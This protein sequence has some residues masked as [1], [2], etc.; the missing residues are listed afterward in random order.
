MRAL[1]R[2]TLISSLLVWCAAAQRGGGGGHGGG[3]GGGG[4]HGGGGMGGGFHGGGSMGGGGGFRGGGGFGGG[5]NRGGFGGG[6][7]R[8]G[9]GYGYGFNRGGY[10]YGRYGYGY[11]GYY[12]GWPYWGYGWGYPGYGWGL[13]VGYWPG[14]FGYYGS[15]DYPYDYGYD[16]G[17]G[18]DPGGYA[19]SPSPNVAV[20][21]QGYPQQGYY[22]QQVVS[23]PAPAYSDTAHPVI[24]SY[25]QYGQEVG[26]SGGGTNGSPIYLIA[27]KDGVIHA[28]ASYWVQQGM[29]HYVTL[30]HEE[31]TVPVANIDHTLTNQLNRERHVNL[32]LVQ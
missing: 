11:R 2:V 26:P 16:S 8:G 29:V 6:F 15:Y 28:A 12:G 7:N 5:F 17:Y 1:L 4:F 23:A 30:Q 3:G 14:Y 24:R 18:Y 27:T 10:G 22:P 25:D 32:N 9:F 19:Y 20:Y 21:Q 31:K 13:G